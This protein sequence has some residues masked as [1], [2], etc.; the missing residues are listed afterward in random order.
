MALKEPA[1]EE[2][3]LR[4]TVTGRDIQI[5]RQTMKETADAVTHTTPSGAERTISLG[6]EKP[7]LFSA[8]APRANSAFTGSAPATSSPSSASARPIRAN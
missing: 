2:E 4:A 6:E 8:E 3:A 1:L 7:G 5:E